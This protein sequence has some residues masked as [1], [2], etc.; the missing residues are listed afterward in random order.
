MHSRAFYDSRKGSILVE[1]LLTVVIL[2]VGLTAIIQAMNTSV[3]GVYHTTGYTTAVLL[4]ENTM[5]SY[6]SKGFVRSGLSE[7][8]KFSPP[9]TAYRYH[10]QTHNVSDEGSSGKKNEVTLTVLWG[11]EGKE[12]KLALVTYLFDES[13]KNETK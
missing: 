11:R 1:V 8:T 10:L 4:A 13:E 9:Y 6:V 2:A 5:F 7:D 12:K 3:R